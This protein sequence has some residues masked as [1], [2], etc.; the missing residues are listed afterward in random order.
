MP[1]GQNKGSVSKARAR[2]TSHSSGPADAG[3]LTPAL[4]F[5][6]EYK[7]LF[8]FSLVVFVPLLMMYLYQR[9]NPRYQDFKWT[10]SNDIGLV[11][12][13][14][15]FIFVVFANRLS[16]IFI[17][18]LNVGWNSYKSNEFSYC[19]WW[20]IGLSLVLFPHIYKAS[21]WPAF[22]TKPESDSL[23]QTTWYSLLGYILVV[24]SI[25]STLSVADKI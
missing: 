11:I 22:P 14:S 15:L 16:P 24:F 4:Y 21:R 12:T 18:R 1:K 10:L 8:L 5:M 6:T 9:G 19:V 13:A 25:I 23:Y 20:G 7:Y 2:I 3:R 17:H